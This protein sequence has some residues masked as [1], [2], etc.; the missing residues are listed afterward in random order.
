MT[1][2]YIVEREWDEPMTIFADSFDQAANLYLAYMALRGDDPEQ[3]SIGRGAR[4]IQDEREREHMRIALNRRE[5][6]I[7][8]YDREEG[9][10]VLP[11]MDADEEGTG[12][13]WDQ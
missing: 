5:I 3:F 1:H 10:R 11:V 13:P 8:R 4:G 6:G 9:W 12:A 7:G 2:A